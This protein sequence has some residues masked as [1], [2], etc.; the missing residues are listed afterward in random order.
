MRF[1][2]I[3]L[4]LGA[5]LTPVV[6]QHNFHA[7]AKKPETKPPAEPRTNCSMATHL[8][9]YE[10]LR[11]ALV[12]VTSEDD[13]GFGYNNLE[14]NTTGPDNRFQYGEDFLVARTVDY[15]SDVPAIRSDVLTRNEIH[16]GT[17]GIAVYCEVCK[18]ILMFKVARN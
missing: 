2:A 8:H 7:S 15:K 3:A 16:R 12:E 9:R 18:A 5:L 10:D 11:L 6:A 13:C 1:L 17:R 14:V 4:I